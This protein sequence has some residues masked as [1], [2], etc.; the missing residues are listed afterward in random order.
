MSRLFK[1]LTLALA[2]LAMIVPAVGQTFGNPT[3]HRVGV[4]T[5]VVPTPTNF[6]ETSKNAP[7]MWESAKT[8]TTASVRVLAHYAPESELKTF[9]AGGEVRL[10]Q[11]MYVQ[12]PVRA[13]GI[14]TTQAQFDKLRTGV[15]ALQNDIAAKISPKLKEEVARASKEFGARQGEPISVKFG[16]IA[17]LSI[18]RNDTKALIYTTLMSVASSQSDASHEG[19]ILSSTA[20]IFA[21]GKVLT[22]SVNRVMNSPRDVQIVRSFASEWVSAILAA[23]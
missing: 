8:F 14:A 9:I 12:T 11:Y 1:Q 10:S 18:D 16:E 13:E 20:F 15:I 22:L 7:E 5:I 23:N 19:N 6:L 17:P 3:S 2:L 21:K 4:E